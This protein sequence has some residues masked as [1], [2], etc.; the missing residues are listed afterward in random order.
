M[1]IGGGGAA[2]CEDR[3]VDELKIFDHIQA[4]CRM[5][6]ADCHVPHRS[7]QD[8]TMWTALQERLGSPE[9][10]PRTLVEHDHQDGLTL[11]GSTLAALKP[12]RQRTKA[13][14]H[15]LVL[16][17]RSVGSGVGGRS[18]PA[19]MSLRYLQ[20]ICL[21]HP[22]MAV[23]LEMRRSHS[24]SVFGANPPVRRSQASAGAGSIPGR[25][26]RVHEGGCP[27]QEPNGNGTSN[28]P[29]SGLLT[30]SLM[31]ERGTQR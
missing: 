18:A 3:G 2:H 22:T 29:K 9:R 13:L 24:S 8:H 28:P 21:S 27:T 23:R 17:V 14:S 1:R 4:P 31:S 6:H 12:C 26:D 16:T 19:A 5:P 25:Q 20:F 30:S 15:D 7:E 10:T 11:G